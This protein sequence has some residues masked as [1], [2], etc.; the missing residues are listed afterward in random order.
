MIESSKIYTKNIYGHIL[1]FFK[2]LKYL[3]VIETFNPSYPRLTLRELP[4][5]T[6][7]SATLTYLC[8]NMYTLDDCLFLLD[9]RIKQ[10][11]TLIVTIGYVDKSSSVIHN[12]V[13]FNRMLIMIKTNYACMI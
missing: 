9:G 8:I 3:S 1:N 6:F 4:S 10:L 7:F 11:S 2:N 12:M 13:S 5:T